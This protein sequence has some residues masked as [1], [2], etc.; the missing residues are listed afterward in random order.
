MEHYCSGIRMHSSISA[1]GVIMKKQ[2]LSR[3]KCGPHSTTSNQARSNI[4]LR[5]PSS[6]VQVDTSSFEDQRETQAVGHVLI[7]LRLKCQPTAGFGSWVVRGPPV[8]LIRLLRNLYE[9]SGGLARPI[10]SWSNNVFLRA[11]FRRDNPGQQALS[12]TN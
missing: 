2:A 11:E 12:L 1:S 5:W 10:A 7:S 4:A 6:G 8:Q 9:E 3:G